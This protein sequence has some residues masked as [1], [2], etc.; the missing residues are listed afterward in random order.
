MSAEIP[1]SYNKN[2]PSPIFWSIC[3]EYFCFALVLGDEKDQQQ[4][5]FKV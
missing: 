3:L 4:H 1:L 5:A 2:F